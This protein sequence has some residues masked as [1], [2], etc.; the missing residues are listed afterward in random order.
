[1]SE[2]KPPGE[3][4]RPGL[5]PAA[6]AAVDVGTVL[7]IFAGRGP[8]L[9]TVTEILARNASYSV[10]RYLDAFGY[11]GQLTLTPYGHVRL[12]RPE[13]HPNQNQ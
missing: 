7:V 6:I 1:M 5:S 12:P 9:V 8:S 13:D 4:A 11:D 2:R 3:V 10:V